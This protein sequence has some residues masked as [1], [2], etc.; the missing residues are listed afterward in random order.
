MNRNEYIRA[1]DLELKHIPENERASILSFYEQ[2]FIEVG[3]SGE[4]ELIQ[5]LGSPASLASRILAQRA[6]RRSRETP[7]NP[8]R[9]LGALWALLLALFALPFALPFLPLLIIGLIVFGAI[10]L[11][12]AIASLAIFI[13]GLALFISGIVSLMSFPPTALILFGTAFL[14]WG[15][16]KIA[17]EIIG[18]L[19]SLIGDSI[20]WIFG[21]NKGTHHAQ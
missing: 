20:L 17:L 5:S 16:G 18:A 7:S 11:G 6:L 19:I 8:V 3:P 14:L 2:R 13:A 10:S 1:L 12:L 9:G 15:L 4:Q 21:S